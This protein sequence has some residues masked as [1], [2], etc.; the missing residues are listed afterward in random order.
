MFRSAGRAISQVSA[1]IRIRYQE[2][3][4]SLATS[5]QGKKEGTIADAFAS[6]SGQ[7]FEALDPRFIAVKAE[8]IKGNED[9]VKASWDRLLLRLQEE[10]RTIQQLGSTVVPQIDFADIDSPSDHFSR[11]YRKRGCAV[12]KGAIPQEEVLRMKEELKEY[13]KTNPSTKGKCIPD[14]VISA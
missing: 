2:Q 12:I 4:R 5:N 6:L 13:I 11:E 3:S 7:K 1:S 10:V 8:L 9:A 14:Y